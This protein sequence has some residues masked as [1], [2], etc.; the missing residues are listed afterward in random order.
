M[1]PHGSYKA[2]DMQAKPQLRP[3]RGGKG[4]RGQG[5]ASF[6]GGECNAERGKEKR[7]REE[8]TGR[9]HLTSKGE[10]KNWGSK[11]RYRGKYKGSFTGQVV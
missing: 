11:R 8:V 1:E 3:L 4:M 10:W 7:S 5:G 2:L 6:R 9:P